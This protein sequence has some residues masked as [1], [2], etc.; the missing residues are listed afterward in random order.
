MS[1]RGFLVRDSP[2]KTQ[3]KKSKSTSNPL[4][5][6]ALLAGKNYLGGQ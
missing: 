1:R 4:I 2:G 3:I 5:L 6:R